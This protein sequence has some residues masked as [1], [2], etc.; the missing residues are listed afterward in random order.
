MTQN[1][2]KDELRT[3]FN[4]NANLKVS[5]ISLYDADSLSSVSSTIY[6]VLNEGIN[7][8]DTN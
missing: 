3:V 8:I 6:A 2:W 1:M 4:S 7:L 5:N